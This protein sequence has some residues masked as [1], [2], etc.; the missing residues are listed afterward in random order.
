M[1]K[2]TRLL[3]LLGL[4]LAVFL[5]FIGLRD[6]A[7]SHEARVVQVARQMA[8]VGWPWNASK[9]EMPQ[10]HLVDLPEGKRLRPVADGATMWVNPWLVPVINRQIR[11]QKPPLP[12]WCSAIL[13]RAFGFGEGVS[14]FIPALLGAISILLMWDLARLLIGRVGA[15]LAALVWVSS[16][17]IVD[18]F[19][20]TMADPYLAFFTMTAIWAWLRATSTPVSSHRIFW[21]VAFYVSLAMGVLAKGPLIFLFVLVI[22]VA[23]H[24]CY[25]RRPPRSWP[26]HVLGCAM[27]IIIAMPWYFVVWRSVPNAMELWR[28]E[29]IGSLSDKVE[30]S[31]SWWFYLPNLLQITLPWT[32]LWLLG[33]TRPVVHRKRRRFFALISTAAI[34]LIF[35][36]F[37]SKKNAYL[38]PLA[39]I[40]TIVIAQGL[41]W[42]IVVLRHRCRPARIAVWRVAVLAVVFAI[43]IQIVVSDVLT[44]ID[45]NRSAKDACRL[46]NQMLS[47]SPRRS[48]L[49]SSMPEEA[50]V[51]LRSD[52]RDEKNSNEVL[53]IADD[54]RGEA[55]ATARA[56]ALTP[57]GPVASIS[58]VPIPNARTARW[59]IFILRIAPPPP[60]APSS[61][62]VHDRSDTPAPSTSSSG[63]PASRENS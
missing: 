41:L 14:R 44:R 45:N 3:I 4:A 10:V 12:Y 2:I 40:Q 13:F 36:V 22:L 9:L 39:P 54:R 43:G 35:S 21:L 27:S 16:F 58:A 42:L 37:N 53:M 29:S 56:V 7:A 47:E 11:L 59:K 17:F 63:S 19:R 31:R 38:L 18:E 30:K 24:L 60:V 34:V 62:P 28:Y 5:P 57:S 1:S 50:S 46:V 48:L 49:V 51:Y 61:G 55:D 25:R 20:K 15:W 6:I 8:A 52:L 32:P 33:L 23:Y 26:G